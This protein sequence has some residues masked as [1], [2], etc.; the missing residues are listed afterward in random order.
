[1][2]VG[3]D[4]YWVGYVLSVYP[5]SVVRSFIYG[6]LVPRVD[7]AMSRRILERRSLVRP[8]GG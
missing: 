2:C 5:E 6:S 7:V 4:V 1:M 8:G 3:L